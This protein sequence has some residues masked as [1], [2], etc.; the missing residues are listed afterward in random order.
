MYKIWKRQH[1]NHILQCQSQRLWIPNYLCWQFHTT[2]RVQSVLTQL[3]ECGCCVSGDRAGCPLITGVAV[4]SLATC[5]NI[6]G[7]GCLA[8]YIPFPRGYFSGKPSGNLRIRT[9]MP[10]KG[11]D[12]LIGSDTALPLQSIL[13]THQEQSS[14]QYLVQGLWHTSDLSD[15]WTTRSTSEPRRWGQLPVAF[16]WCCT[17]RRFGIKF[18]PCLWPSVGIQTKHNMRLLSQWRCCHWLICLRV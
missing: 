6:L 1:V 3:Q 7:I 17:W 8:L 15:K 9:Q 14:V 2:D 10:R 12:L 18:W 4:L 13:F 11:A 5:R 16:F